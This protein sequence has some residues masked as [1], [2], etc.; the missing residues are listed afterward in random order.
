MSFSDKLEHFQLAIARIIAGA[1]KGTNHD[2]LYKETNCPTLSEG[3]SLN[4]MKQTWKIST[5][6]C[7][8]YL[9]HIL[10]DKIGQ[11]SQYRTETYNNS[12]IPSTVR[13][14]NKL[15]MS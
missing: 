12:F 5:H 1:R 10:Q 3:C 7:P 6:R 13:K 11:T 2:L 15:P 14:C 4:C 8:D 9:A